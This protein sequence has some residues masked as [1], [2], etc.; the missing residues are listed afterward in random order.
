MRRYLAALGKK[1]GEAAH[2][3]KKRQPPEHYQRMVQI[4]AENRRRRKAAE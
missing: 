4:R 3:D 2:G 1:G